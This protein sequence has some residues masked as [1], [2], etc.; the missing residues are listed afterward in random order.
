MAR[1]ENEHGSF[2]APDG[3]TLMP[4]LGAAGCA[5]EALSNPQAPHPSVILTGDVRPEGQ[6]ITAYVAAQLVALE[7]LLPGWRSIDGNVTDVEPGP[8]VVRHGFQPPDQ[9]WV[10]QFQAYWFAGP[11]VAIMTM[12]TPAT[13]TTQAWE[14]F[15]GAVSTFAPPASVA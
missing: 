1:V 7:K 3:W 4:G 14:V 11:R 13:L 5:P 2:E 6:S 10:V 15:A 9:G 12:T 8:A